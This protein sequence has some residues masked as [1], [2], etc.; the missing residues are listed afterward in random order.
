MDGDGVVVGRAPGRT[1]DGDGGAAGR[2]SGRTADGDGGA[3]DV[4]VW[5]GVFLALASVLGTGTVLTLVLGLTPGLSKGGGRR[6]R[7]LV[8]LGLAVVLF[9]G[10]VGGTKGV[11]P[12]S[13]RACS[14]AY[15]I[16]ARRGGGPARLDMA[17]VGLEFDLLTL[18]LQEMKGYTPVQ[19]GLR[20]PA[21][22]DGDRRQYDG[23]TRRAAVRGGERA[24]RRVRRRDRGPALALPGAAR[25]AYAADLLPGLLLSGWGH[26]AIYTS[27]F[28]IGAHD[29][30][31]AHQST[32]GALLTTSQYLSGAV[33]VACPDAVWV[34]LPGHGDLRI[35]FS[36]TTA[37][38]LGGAPAAARGR[39]GIAAPADPSLSRGSS[40]IVTLEPFAGP[41]DVSQ[42]ASSAT[43]QEGTRS[44]RA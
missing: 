22:G 14:A 18:L 40:Q 13:H 33:T 43:G 9:V 3:D 29:V 39:S 6:G 1:A 41:P 2:T 23:G 26:G 7:T 38:A 42:E 20:P 28:I 12:T 44:H 27:M 37:A 15:E 35:A 25:D 34:L 16:V 30:P 21:G 8:C 10:F 24:R 19:A 4:G 36:L 17:S 31:D 5:L 11:S 32:A